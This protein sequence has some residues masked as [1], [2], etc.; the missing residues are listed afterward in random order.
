MSILIDHW[1]FDPFLAI[2][3]AVAVLHG[4]GIHRLCRGAPVAR[5][6]R[7]RREAAWFYLGLAT[8]VIAVSSPIDYW[9]DS[10][11]WVHMCQHLLLMF[12]APVP[13]LLGAPW[14]ALLRGLPTPLRRGVVRFGARSKWAAPL[15]SAVRSRR[16]PLVGV[17]GLNAT[18]V[19]WHLPGPFDLAEE[20]P[21]VHIWAMHG[22][23]FLFGMLFWLQLI[24][25]R[26]LRVRLSPAA[27]MGA[28]FATATIMWMLAIALSLCSQASWY[29]WYRS[30]EGPMLPAFADQQI[31]AGI[32]WTCGIF[33]AVPAMIRSVRRLIDDRGA[34]GVDA[35]VDRVLAGRRLF[36]DPHREGSRASYTR[37]LSPVAASHHR[38][39]GVVQGAAGTAT[40]PALA[41]RTALERQ[42][43][44]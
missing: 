2:V 22:S 23:F 41:P 17:V 31:G 18:I 5:V 26:P 3:A 25:S 35:L 20:N 34:E 40:T 16:W 37:G 33:W 28:I 43:G 9:S 4:L 8:L 24:E 15:R 10:Y 36:L 6:R 11:F 7:R 38:P 32:M 27:Q 13:I 30:H 42:Q 44:P 21:M 14:L 12:A 19:F 1:S 39:A 29:G